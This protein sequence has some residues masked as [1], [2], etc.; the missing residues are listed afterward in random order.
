MAKFNICFHSRRI[1]G[2][3]K[4]QVHLLVCKCNQ[5]YLFKCN[6]IF[7]NQ[8]SLLHSGK[9]LIMYIAIDGNIT[10]ISRKKLTC[11]FMYVQTTRFPLFIYHIF[12][13][14]QPK[15]KTKSRMF[16]LRPYRYYKQDVLLVLHHPCIGPLS[17]R[18][19]GLLSHYCSWAQYLVTHLLCIPLPIRNK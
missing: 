5:F 6:Q 19:Y 4:S 11:V 17:D 1:I 2:D 3:K 14:P 18:A 9:N 13:N 7:C 16:S 12:N 8:I 10:Y 15:R